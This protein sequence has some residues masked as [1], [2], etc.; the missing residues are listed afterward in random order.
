M[1][2]HQWAMICEGIKVQSPNKISLIGVTDTIYVKALP[3]NP[4]E[5]KVVSFII[6]E[7]GEKFTYNIEIFD[8]DGEKADET[9]EAK[10]E[11]IES[12]HTFENTVTGVIFHKPGQHLFRVF[13]NDHLVQTIPLNIKL[14]VH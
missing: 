5:I 8:P 13:L 3:Y 4:P 14:I 1:P 2:D 9:I 6:G 10:L 7:I 11:L 12:G